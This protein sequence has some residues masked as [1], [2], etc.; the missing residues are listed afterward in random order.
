M[1]AGACGQRVNDIELFCAILDI[2]PIAQGHSGKIKEYKAGVRRGR[3]EEETRG[4]GD[5]AAKAIQAMAVA[6][7]LSRVIGANRIRDLAKKHVYADGSGLNIAG[8]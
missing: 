4:R 2:A 8:N 7:S 6:R 1:G 3:T 5:G